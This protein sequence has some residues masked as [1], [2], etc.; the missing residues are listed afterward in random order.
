MAGD[1][2]LIVLLVLIGWVI[3]ALLQ[4]SVRRKKSVSPYRK[5]KTNT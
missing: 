1:A 4:I 3:V 2:L 5:E